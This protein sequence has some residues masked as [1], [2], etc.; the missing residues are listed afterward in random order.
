MQLDKVVA[1]PGLIVPARTFSLVREDGGFYMIFT[2]RA[3]MD[4]SGSA[5]AAL[6]A[7]LLRRKATK[8]A[9]RVAEG[10]AKLQEQGAAALANTKY[11]QYV[12]ADSIRS[13][14]V[15]SSHR[16]GHFPTVVVKAAKKTTL[17][18]CHQD[19]Q[20]VHVFFAPFLSRAAA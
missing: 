8:Y 11:S 14:E 18:F 19:E 13:I 16:W 1:P 9:V 3:M 5:A 12:P 4:V 17:I 20:T 10:E 7:P 6:A 2:G 15:F